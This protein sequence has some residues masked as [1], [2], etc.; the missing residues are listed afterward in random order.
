MCLFENKNSLSVPRYFPFAASIC[1]FSLIVRMSIGNINPNKG[2][3]ER[4]SKISAI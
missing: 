2:M 4:P 3:D 1:L